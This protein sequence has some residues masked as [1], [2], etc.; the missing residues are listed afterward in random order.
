MA[1]KGKFQQSGSN[2]EAAVKQKKYK[3]AVIV[4]A[5]AALILLAA[6]WLWGSSSMKPERVRG[7]TFAIIVFQSFP[8]KK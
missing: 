4:A 8:G 2:A 7:D 5:G 6:I 1:K 3:K